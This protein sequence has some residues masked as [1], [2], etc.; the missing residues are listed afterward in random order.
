MGES[1]QFHKTDLQAFAEA[2]HELHT[3]TCDLYTHNWFARALFFGLVVDALGRVPKG[4][5]RY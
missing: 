4:E 2:V 5:G 3:G 1:V